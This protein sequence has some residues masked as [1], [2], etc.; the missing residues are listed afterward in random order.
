MKKVLIVDDNNAI[1]KMVT[2]ILKKAGYDVYEAQDGDAAIR[3]LSMNEEIDV[4]LLDIMMPNLD[5]KETLKKLQNYKSDKKLKICMM[6]ALGQAED[7]S[8][9]LG[10][11]ADDYIIKPIEK[12]NLQE[13][14]YQLINDSLKTKFYACEVEEDA[15]ILIPNG[16]VRI[17]IKNMSEYQFEFTSEAKIP[18]NAKAIFVSDV[19][20]EVFGTNE[21]IFAKIYAEYDY[22]GEKR[23]KAS[24]VGLTEKQT[25]QMRAATITKA[26]V[27]EEQ[28]TIN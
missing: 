23:Y 16:F 22:D 7:I 28:D 4:M 20:E 15:K 21:R 18:L 19:F 10:L 25:K 2:I 14:I 17:K 24:Y 1:R 12:E 9:C 3:L 11:G 5:G 6:T 27:H 26:V 13:K 8:S